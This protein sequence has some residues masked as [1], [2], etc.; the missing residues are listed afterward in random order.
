MKPF[1]RKDNELR[2]RVNMRLWR[3][4]PGRKGAFYMFISSLVV[5][6]MLMIF[7]VYNS[8]K[9]VDEQ[10]VVETRIS[11]LNDFIKDIDSDSDRVMYVSGY[12]S[13]IA[14]EDYIAQTGAYLNDSELY[15]KE[16]F[17]NGTVNGTKVEVLNASSYYDY[18]EKLRF[19]SRKVGIDLF[20]NVTDIQLYH[21]TPWTVT[22]VV[23]ADVYINDTRGLAYWSF[24]KEYSTQ[25]PLTNIRD[26]VYSVGTGGNVPNT[27]RQTNVTPGE[28]VIDTSNDTFGLQ[29]HNNN[30]FYYENPMA[31]SFLMRLEGNFSPSE[32]GIESIVYLPELDTQGVA[33]DSEKSLIDYVFFTNITGFGAVTCNVKNMSGWFKIDLNHTETYEVNKLNYTVC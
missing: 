3:L 14:M 19:I 1:H 28:F 13:L 4:M 21:E 26:P 32:H 15:F 27:I 12:R 5:I 30:T 2:R 9:F 33:Y 23:T 16:A 31:P 7:G 10:K 25:I 29:T 20:L 22:V 18:M 11:T 6:V 8:Y 17:Y 24:E